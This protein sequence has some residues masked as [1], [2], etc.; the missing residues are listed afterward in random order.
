M[1]SLAAY[2]PYIVL[3]ALAPLIGA[4]VLRF[5]YP[6]VRIF[7]PSK[8][9]AFSIA[10]GLVPY[11]PAAYLG[12]M[13]LV[14][15]FFTAGFSLVEWEQNALFFMGSYFAFLMA[16]ASIVEYRRARKSSMV[17]L[18]KKII[19][20]GVQEERKKVVKAAKIL[21]KKREVDIE[22]ITKEL[23][24]AA[25]EKVKAPEAEKGPSEEE[26][27]GK[28]LREELERVAKEAEEEKRGGAVN[29][30]LNQLKESVKMEQMA[31][32]MERDKIL[33]E[34][35]E[36]IKR[37]K[38]AAAEEAPSEKDEKVDLLLSALREK[39]EKQKELEKT[40]DKTEKAKEE[41]TKDD[42]EGITR[43]LREL[44][45]KEKEAGKE[46]EAEEKEGQEIE[47]KGGR[48][49]RRHG[50][51]GRRTERREDKGEKEILKAVVGDVREQL[52]SGG[53]E[54]K[55]EEE[56]GEERWYEKAPTP[57]KAEK[58]MT[59]E[60]EMP[61]LMPE[62]GL[63]G[64][65]IELFE[66]GLD[67]GELGAGAELDEGSLSEFGDELGELD[68]ELGGEDYDGMFVDLKVKNACPTCGKKGT[69][70]VYCSSCGK[71][72]CSNCAKDIKVEGDLVY[73]TC[74]NC[75]EVTVVKKR[76][77]AA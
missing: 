38:E 59:G 28:A 69:T 62:A 60:E 74:P 7:R 75:D 35:K 33:G 14:V 26:K 51:R 77:T 73:Y 11:I 44:R 32:Q 70:V 24:V 48:A 43:A 39:L 49:P 42:I 64:E 29:S 34:L 65:G 10:F 63:E 30:I 57:R 47:K 9:W 46:K 15:P 52:I 66:E 54:E 25:E 53:E 22:K 8:R 71:P 37:R 5:V 1:P 16:V 20:F 36:E 13:E 12:I 72:F 23:E 17:V 55:E 31:R 50:R 58:G 27:K 19:K 67:F 18:P 76:E 56:E 40:I 61:E 21:H 6:D 45:A 3:L 2:V 4:K 41:I 68:V